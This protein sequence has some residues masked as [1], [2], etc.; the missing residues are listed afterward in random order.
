MAA[1]LMRGIQRADAARFS[2]LL[3]TPAFLGAPLLQLADIVT[4]DVTIES[5][6]W[7]PML[8]GF[9]AAA[10]T[11]VLAIRWLLG[12]LRNHSFYVFSIYTLV[13]GLITIAVSFVR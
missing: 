1:G 4:G 8:A 10:I 5:I 12:Y 11:G 6:A 2:F 7:L 9:V 3:G 13:V